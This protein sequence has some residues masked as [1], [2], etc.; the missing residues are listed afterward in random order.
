MY[1]LESADWRVESA[2]YS[3]THFNFILNHSASLGTTGIMLL[4]F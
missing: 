4:A 1:M 3:V 2:F